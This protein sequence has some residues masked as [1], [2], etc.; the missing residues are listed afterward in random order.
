VLVQFYDQTGFNT[1][2]GS[3]VWQQI[4]FEAD[5]AYPYMGRDDSSMI[6]T[7]FLRL[8]TASGVYKFRCN[9]RY[10]AARMWLDGQLV[11]NN[12]PLH[13]NTSTSY[14]FKLEVN[15]YN[16]RPYVYFDVAGPYASGEAAQQ[17]GN[18]DW[19][20]LPSTSYT[21]EVRCP[22]GCSNRGCCVADGQCSCQPG[23][24][25][26][27]CSVV[28]DTCGEDAPRGNL[29]EGGLRARY[30]ATS[31]FA[32]ENLVVE[33]ID[34]RV[35]LPY[36]ALPSGVPRDT[37]SA[38]W[39]GRL[40]VIQTGWHV[41]GLESNSRS[42]GRIVLGGVNLFSWAESW[43]TSVFLDRDQTYSLEVELYKVDRFDTSLNVFWS[44]PGF[45]RQ[46][47]PARN[48]FYYAEGFECGCGADDCTNAVHGSCL[49]GNCICDPIFEG[50]HCENYRCRSDSCFGHDDCYRPDLA[51][52]GSAAADCS[53]RGACLA[54]VCT[55]DEGFSSL[56]DCRRGGCPGLEDGGGVV[57]SGHGV[58]EGSVCICN[59]EFHG[60][61]CAYSVCAATNATLPGLQVTYF[62]DY[63][64]TAEVATEVRASI[65]RGSSSELFPGTGR[66][67]T[68]ASYVGRI[69]AF[70]SGFYRFQCPRDDGACRLQ[71]NGTEIPEG[72]PA[73]LP[74]ASFV[75]FTVL[76][77]H[78]YG[79]DYHR[80]EWAGPYSST[81]EAQGD[82]SPQYTVVPSAQFS[83]AV[84]CPGGCGDHGCCAAEGFCRCEYGWTGDAC[85]VELRNCAP[86]DSTVA[87]FTARMYADQAF[88]TLGAV[89]QYNALDHYYSNEPAEGL[90]RDGW[91]IEATAF[92]EPLVT[93]WHTFRAET[94]DGQIRLLIGG[95]VALPMSS[96]FTIQAYFLAGVRTAFVV[97]YIDDA[98]YGSG[99]RV[100]SQGPNQHREILD[101]RSA[102]YGSGQCA[103]APCEPLATNNFAPEFTA[104]TLVELSIREDQ[105]SST[106]EVRRIGARDPDTG[107]SLACSSFS[108]LSFLGGVA[109][110]ANASGTNRPF[111]FMYFHLPCTSSTIFFVLLSPSLP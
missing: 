52:G 92:Y 13:L 30:Y 47:I 19:Q 18:N 86:D 21:H 103:C 7:G 12:E 95:R 5:Q 56:S 26:R 93:G 70:A 10:D 60:E 107:M 84:S 44:G 38:R 37:F 100:Y 102:V 50:A 16:F 55:C 40:K 48:L 80:L 82:A 27:D 43:S 73:Y 110:S 32:N 106:S 71:L 4:A 25:G 42:R 109:C 53:G 62:S 81:A 105:S 57:C 75:P 41:I 58:C 39:I 8:Q 22:D 63:D 85:D 15:H 6:M 24:G 79:D 36:G 28:L 88:G 96:G 61:D 83:H 29:Q 14:R 104:T 68:S 35:F 89:T 78:S 69:H 98:W 94:L 74:A 9:N 87:G 3:L 91:S 51:W 77:Q 72:E 17:A 97:Q 2:L 1:L 59:D 65:N 11:E 101:F 99:F 49:N 45:D 64:L 66:D 23:F 111:L 34:E 46:T 108:P 20:L 33:R 90:P 54:G 67:T 76:R 31:N